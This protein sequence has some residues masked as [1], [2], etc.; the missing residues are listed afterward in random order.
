MIVCT[1]PCESRNELCLSPKMFS[2]LFKVEVLKIHRVS[3]GTL[4]ELQHVC[5]V[6]WA[7][8]SR[9][10]ARPE[11]GETLTETGSE[12]YRAWY[13]IIPTSLSPLLRM[14]CILWGLPRFLS[15]CKAMQE[16]LP[17]SLYRISPSAE[18]TVQ[19]HHTCAKSCRGQ[20]P[21]WRLA[22]SVVVQRQWVR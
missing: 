2:W 18:V 16:T 6:L 9:V 7:R 12:V 3:R 1:K 22:K 14:A 5:S 19:Y 17:T 10:L 21:C 4:V 13:G 20:L 15:P 8:G 11:T